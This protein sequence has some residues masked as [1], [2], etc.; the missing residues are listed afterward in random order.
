[1]STSNAVDRGDTS[2]PKPQISA[3][4]SLPARSRS[5]DSADKLHNQLHLPSN[6]IR[7]KGSRPPLAQNEQIDDDW[8]PIQDDDDVQELGRSSDQADTPDRILDERDRD[9]AEQ[10]KD[11]RNQNLYPTLP[12]EPTR[13]MIDHQP[14]A[15]VEVWNGDLS[16]SDDPPSQMSQMSK[17]M[18]F[19]QSQHSNTQEALQQHRK[20]PPIRPPESHQSPPKRRRVQE[21]KTSR[22]REVTSSNPLSRASQAAPSSS[23]SAVQFAT[24]V[25]KD[26]VAIQGS[27]P[28]QSRVGWS[29]EETECLLRLISE[30][31]CSWSLIQRMD[32]KKILHRRDQVGLKDKA[33]NLKMIF[34]K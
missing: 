10:T 21:S 13:R 7:R 22:E 9:L 28:L 23:R 4:P 12:S 15:H 34:L 18:G 26:V 25:A 19:Q 3:L 2:A 16:E 20:R 14:D 17:D 31:G 8:Q 32:T 33:R 27:K 29:A 11:S 6:Q 1:M 30:H 5:P 24:Q